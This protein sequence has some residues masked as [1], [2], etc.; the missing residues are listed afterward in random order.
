MAEYLIKINTDSL[1]N[2]DAFA[3]ATADELRVLLALIAHGEEPI[4]ED[5][6]A[7]LA[8]TSKSRM[9][10]A[11]TLFEEEG[12][13]EEN[14]SNENI[15]YEFKAR[16]AEATSLETAKSIRDNSLH[17][18]L[19]ECEN[20]F[21][22]S[23]GYRESAI[24]TGL[25]EKGITPEYILTM[26]G[27]LVSSRKRVTAAMLERETLA[28]INKGIT[29]L[30]ELEMY[31]EEKTKEVKGEMEIRRLFGIYGRTLTPT[32][33]KFIKKWFEEYAYSEAIIGEA[34]DICVNATTT[35]SF[36]YIDTVLSGW[37]SKGCKTLA[38]CKDEA[39]AHRNEYKVKRTKKKVKETASTSI[40]KYSTFDINEAIE[41]ALARSFDD[42]DDDTD[43]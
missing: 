39:E 34:Y 33:R 26:L 23:F 18:L 8:K 1:C 5:E 29:T 6:L 15:V 42:D 14:S 27:Y 11:I 19:A 9:K 3:E 36:S 35:L 30:E 16:K 24:I 25:A 17:E 40:P 4:S 31:I 28:K 20:L 13:I 37:H 41:N 7:R 2:S 38:E 43:D 12:I 22:G 32:E 21:G 10:A